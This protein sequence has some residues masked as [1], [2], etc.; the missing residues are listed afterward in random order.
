MKKEKYI[1]S[2]IKYEKA[3]LI[4]LL[5]IVLSSLIF[6]PIIKDKDQGYLLI[7]ITYSIIMIIDLV[8][9]FIAKKNDNKKYKWDDEFM[10]GLISSKTRMSYIAMLLTF[11]FSLLLVSIFIPLLLELDNPLIITI[12]FFSIT[13]LIMIECGIFCK[14]LIMII[15]EKE[16]SLIQI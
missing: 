13:I 5:F 7:T 9:L 1:N 2:T 8:L 14:R 15:I 3:M 11:L 16:F 6:I 12:L 10:P 4:Y